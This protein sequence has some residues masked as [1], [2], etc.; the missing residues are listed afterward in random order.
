M[1]FEEGLVVLEEGRSVGERLLQGV[2]G[3]RA[4]LLEKLRTLGLEFPHWDL[5][6]IGIPCKTSTIFKPVS[7]ECAYL[8]RT[9]P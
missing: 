3:Q 9:L 8:R 1:E 6:Q 7:G 5:V 4:V 2:A